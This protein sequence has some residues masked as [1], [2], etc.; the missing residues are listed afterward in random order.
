MRLRR[1]FL[2]AA[3]ALLALVCVPA[4]PAQAYPVQGDLP[5]SVLLCKFA[6]RPEEPRPPQFFRELFTD[7]GKGLG[8]FADYLADQS[9]GRTSVAGSVV[10]GWYTMPFTLEQARTKDR[11]QRIEDCVQTAAA[12]GYT[13]PSNHW[14]AVMIN[15]PVDSGSWGKRVLL[16]PLAWNLGFTTHE[17]LHGYDRDHSFSDDPTYR[18]ADWSQIGEYDDEWDI[19][20]AMHIHTYETERFGT[21]AVGLNGPTRDEMGWLEPHRIVTLGADGVAS[22][23]VRLVP[24]DQPSKVGT[25]MVRVPFDAADPFHYYTVEF[26][27]K[28]GQSAGIPADIVLLHEV[29]NGVSYLLKDRITRNPVTSL[30]TNGVSI[31]IDS[32]GQDEAVVT[33]SANLTQKCLNGYVHRKATYDDLVC[34]TPAVYEQTQADTADAANWEENGKCTPS[35]TRRLATPSDK[36]CVPA[37]TRRQVVSDNA[38]AASRINPARLVLGPNACKP[39]FVWRG[40]DDFDQVCVTQDVRDQVIADNM[41]GAGRWTNGPDGPRSCIQ[42]YVWREAFAGD[43]I[44]VTLDRRERALRDTHTSWERVLRPAG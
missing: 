12:A 24:L 19:M 40:A 30:N 6:D 9:G 22:R 41:M 10:K 20:S 31:S 21:S 33:A 32:V 8:G 27:K 34:V 26:R 18:N 28:T 35:Y 36:V 16:D 42:G 13:V 11:W 25:R 3:I 37:G 17:L 23:T 44:C 15:A 2:T 5:W 38:I 14:T 43:N 7:A 4:L 1:S 29:K 39:G